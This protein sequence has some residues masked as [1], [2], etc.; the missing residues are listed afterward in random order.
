MKSTATFLF[1]GMIVFIFSC[2]KSQDPDAE[3]PFINSISFE[4]LPAKDVQFDPQKRTITI[5]LP[6]EVPEE[7]LIPVV[8][9]S[10]NTEIIGGLAS[11]GALDLSAFCDCPGYE[12]PKPEGKLVLA[13]DARTRT[14][15]T[16]R[17]YRVI[18][19]PAKGNLEPIGELPITYARSGSSEAFIEIALPLKNLY[20]NP[21]LYGISLK[22]LT[23]GRDYGY[24]LPGDICVNYGKADSPN[25]MIVSYDKRASVGVDGLPAGTYE[26][27]ISLSQN[28]AP[29]TFPQ[30][31]VIKE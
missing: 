22:N 9:L 19:L 24:T 14:Y 21:Q 25:R 10:K 31:L 7:G 5:Q 18:A 12:K 17:S 27:T 20:Q 2:K 15:R 28:S 16:Q 6:A 4:N 11:N 30:P 26:V 3:K 1:V 13:N 23:T 8:E 29:L